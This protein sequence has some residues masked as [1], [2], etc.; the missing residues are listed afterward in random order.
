MSA[1]AFN[2]WPGRPA[3]PTHTMIAIDE[4]ATLR[5]CRG[6]L[7]ELVCWCT[8]RDHLLTYPSGEPIEND[9]N[10]QR[11]LQ[12]AWEELARLRGD[13]EPPVDLET[14]LEE[15]GLDDIDFAKA[16]GL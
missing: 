14:Q 5:R 6:V 8:L 7:A 9:I 3:E 2:N 11:L 16:L 15:L 1:P 10:L 4:L 12:Q 13:P